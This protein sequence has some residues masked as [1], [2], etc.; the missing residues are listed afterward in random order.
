MCPS[1]RSNKLS[2]GSHG[3]GDLYWLSQ[4]TRILQGT[5]HGWWSE[6]KTRATLACEQAP[7]GNVDSTSVTFRGYSLKFT[8]G[9]CRRV[10]E[11]LDQFAD[12]Y[13]SADF[14]GYDVCSTSKYCSHLCL[15][16]SNAHLFRCACPDDME[17]VGTLY[18]NRTCKCRESGQFIDLNGDC[19]YRKYKQAQPVHRLFSLQRSWSELLTSLMA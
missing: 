16:D 3:D 4:S 12:L 10:Y 8:M 14:A 7:H 9:V 18:W 5:F 15:P 17:P 6:R 1:K 11:T 13:V 2:G 19:R